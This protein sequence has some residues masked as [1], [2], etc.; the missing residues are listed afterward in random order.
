MDVEVFLL[1]LFVDIWI[2]FPK[3]ESCLLD[4][5]LIVQVLLYKI[6]YSI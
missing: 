2:L 4:G 6:T 5:C 1:I 3:A